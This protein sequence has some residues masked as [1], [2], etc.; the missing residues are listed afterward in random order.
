MDVS[1]SR[2]QWSIARHALGKGAGSREVEEQRRQVRVLDK[3][4]AALNRESIDPLTVT[5]SRRDREML[6]GMLDNP[7]MPFKVDVLKAIIWPIRAALGFPVV[8]YGEEEED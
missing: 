1:M 5:L 2:G 8:D 3:L 6:V 4:D 7:A